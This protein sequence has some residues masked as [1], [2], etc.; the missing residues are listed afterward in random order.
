L[1]EYY[2]VVNRTLGVEPDFGKKDSGRDIL[3]NPNSGRKEFGG[4]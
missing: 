4:L 2:F 1:E 3:A